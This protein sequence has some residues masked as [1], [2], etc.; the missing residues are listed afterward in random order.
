MLLTGKGGL[1]LLPYYIKLIFFVTGVRLWKSSMTSGCNKF[2]IELT[3]SPA[4]LN[5]TYDELEEDVYTM[6]T[7]SN[8]ATSYNYTYI[9]ILT[10]MISLCVLSVLVNM[11]ILTSLFW[12]RR[13]I[14]PTLHI[15][16]SLALSDLVTLV[17]DSIGLTV[18][19]LI[20]VGFAVQEEVVS[21][22]TALLIETLRMGG[23]LTTV[24]HLLA[25]AGNHYLGIRKP[26]HYPSL[27]TFKSITVITSI[28]WILPTFSFIVYLY[29][30]ECDGFA[31]PEC[32]YQ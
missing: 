6:S 32:S 2:P 14:S 26:L 16:I 13:P 21:Q 25:L 31:V 19:S 15:S 20:P 27:M 9:Y 7:P 17:I 4:D 23:R 22:C 29:S 18:N 10:P 11:V 12:I 1:E 3:R 24:G 5:T 28:L 8:N 30:L